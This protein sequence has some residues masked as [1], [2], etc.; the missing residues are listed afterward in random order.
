VEGVVA[1]DVAKAPHLGKSRD[2]AAGS[3]GVSPRYVSEAKRVKEEAPDAFEALRAGTTPSRRPCL[4]V[5][6]EFDHRFATIVALERMPE[7]VECAQPACRLWVER[8]G[9]RFALPDADGRVDAILLIGDKI[10][11]DEPMCM[12]HRGKE[13]ALCALDGLLYAFVIDRP[14]FDHGI[15]GRFRWVLLRCLKVIRLG[16]SVASLL[17]LLGGMKALTAASHGA[18]N[19]SHLTIFRP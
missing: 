6:R 16:R 19:T 5:A 1:P 12:L 17:P 9:V 3:V 2:Q 15:H 13:F 14:P 8:L 7:L 18:I 11:A 10:E 4:R